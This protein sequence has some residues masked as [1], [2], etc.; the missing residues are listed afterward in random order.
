[1][2]PLVR[3]NQE[4]QCLKYSHH[5]LLLCQR[6]PA[7]N[8]AGTAPKYPQPG[9]R[10]KHSGLCD[11]CDIS[12]GEHRHIPGRQIVVVLLASAMS[13]AEVSA[14]RL[15]CRHRD[16]LVTENSGGSLYST[17]RCVNPLLHCPMGLELAS[18][19]GDTADHSPFPPSPEIQAPC[20]AKHL[21]LTR[22]YLRTPRGAG[23]VISRLTLP[24]RVS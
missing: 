5:V 18:C 15:A 16:C 19:V 4:R 22:H 1:M 8:S 2:I 11:L 24:P 12:I 23:F 14:V 7:V 21:H 20:L 6:I 13:K 9:H 17:Q 10:S 3:P